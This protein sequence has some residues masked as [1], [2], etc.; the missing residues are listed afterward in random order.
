MVHFLDE[1]IIVPGISN[2]EDG[3]SH[4]CN[5][6]IASNPNVLGGGDDI[7]YNVHFRMGIL[8]EGVS[9]SFIARNEMGIGLTLKETE[10][11]C[12]ALYNLAKQNFRATKTPVEIK[13][14]GDNT[15]TYARASYVK[16]SEANERLLAL[17]ITIEPAISTEGIAK[18]TLQTQAQ[19][20]AFFCSAILSPQDA[21]ILSYI[22]HCS[23][24][25]TY[26]MFA[27][28]HQKPSRSSAQ[29][30]PEPESDGPTVLEEAIRYTDQVLELTKK[31]YNPDSRFD[32]AELATEVTMLMIQI[33]QGYRSGPFEKW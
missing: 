1:R 20:N 28:D 17:A 22:L 6:N 3:A 8:E 10:V 2:L 9:P 13:F 33:I 4:P 30:K 19:D 5:L 7:S 11:F 31:H 25:G 18:I 21:L 29:S 26:H 32:Y 15:G 16:R 12:E 27:R 23:Y 24:L 14:S